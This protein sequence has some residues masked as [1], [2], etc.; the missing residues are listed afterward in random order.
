MQTKPII[1]GKPKIH[2]KEKGPSWKTIFL[3]NSGGFSS[4]G[5][6]ALLKSFKFLSVY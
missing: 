5:V 6:N 1:Y 4:K 2:N 3:K